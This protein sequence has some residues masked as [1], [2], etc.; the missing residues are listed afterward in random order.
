M[1]G[2]LKYGFKKYNLKTELKGRKWNTKNITL[3]KL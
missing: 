1:Y 2:K 3:T